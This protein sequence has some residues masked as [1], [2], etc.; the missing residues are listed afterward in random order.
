[1]KGVQSV[2]RE[3]GYSMIVFDSDGGVS[4]EIKFLNQLNK[5]NVSGLVISTPHVSSEYIMAVRQ[6][7]IPYVLAYGYSTEPD[8]PCVYINNLEAK[9]SPLCRN[10]PLLDTSVLLL[11]AVLTADLTI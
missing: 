4:E 5:Y 7:G 9:A 1:M 8:V 10:C 11:S 6:L 3:H 2:L